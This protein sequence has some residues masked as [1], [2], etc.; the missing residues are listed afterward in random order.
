MKRYFGSLVK[1]I[2]KVAH[3]VFVARVT[4]SFVERLFPIFGH[5]LTK[6][7]FCQILQR[8]AISASFFAEQLKVLKNTFSANLSF[9]LW[10]KFLLS[11]KDF[12]KS[13][14]FV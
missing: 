14:Y 3:C 1:T 13:S 5:T 9:L 8:A 7:L 6:Q 11:E 4:N 2:F 10:Q 12:K